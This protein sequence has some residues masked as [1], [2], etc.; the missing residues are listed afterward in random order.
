[1]ATDDVLISDVGRVPGVLPPDCGH[2]DQGFV[3]AS[4][5]ASTQPAQRQ[6][7]TLRQGSRPG[8]ATQFGE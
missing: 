5:L 2:V 3:P 8:S 6:R 4:R 7:G 1:M